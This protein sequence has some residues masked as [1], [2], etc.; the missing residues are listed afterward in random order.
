MTKARDFTGVRFGKLLIIE[1]AERIG[2]RR[3]YKCLC[4]CGNTKNIRVECFSNGV[5]K[6]CGCIR[7]ERIALLNKTHGKSNSSEY[8]SWHHAKERIFNPNDKKYFYYGGRGI[9]MDEKWALNFQSFYEDMGDK[10]SK[11]HSI[12]RIDVNE[13]YFKWNCRW[14]NS[15]Q[16]A[17]AR[18]D[19]VYVICNDKKM[20]LKDA[21]KTKNINYKMASKN[22]KN[23]TWLAKEIFK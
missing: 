16:Q 4:D 8:K 18:T 23:G 7:N 21:C 10:P 2:N 11:N 14:E 15:K 9:K 1:L 12:G 6:S 20:I 22:L 17:R 5:T 3:A 19:N 13:G